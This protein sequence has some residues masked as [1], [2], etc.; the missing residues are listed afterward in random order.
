MGRFIS[1]GHTEQPVT[2][3]VWMPG[4]LAPKFVKLA[5]PVIAPVPVF[6]A[7]IPAPA[8]AVTTEE[9]WTAPASAPAVTDM[10]AS[11]YATAPM[12]AAKDMSP[13]EPEPSTPP[14][15]SPVPLATPPAAATR[16]PLSHNLLSIRRTLG[17]TP[18]EFARPIIEDGEGLINRLETGFSRPSA[19]IGNLICEVWGI[20]KDYL[21]SGTGP[22]FQKDEAASP[23]KYIILLTTLLKSYLSVATFDKRGNQYWKSSLVDDLSKIVDVKKLDGRNMSRVI[24][25]L[26]DYLDVDQFAE[27]L[28]RFGR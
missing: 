16:A 10:S 6:T 9:H 19:E 15:P 7:P 11:V 17:L 20:R 8:Q 5:A 18:E 21:Y 22:M 25:V 13:S 26:Y 24:R 12:A 3:F 27:I 1:I 2:P 23:E 14:V 28:E 4:R